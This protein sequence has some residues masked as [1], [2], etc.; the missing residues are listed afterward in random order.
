MSPT[1]VSDFFVATPRCVFVRVG[2]G[3]EAE[4]G[5]PYLERESKSAR[6]RRRRLYT[7]LHTHSQRSKEFVVGE[8][9]IRTEDGRRRRGP[10]VLAL[11]FPSR[12]CVVLAAPFS[13]GRRLRRVSLS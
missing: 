9:I 6:R 4:G 12:V 5:R 2:L 10:L 13:I 7:T 11:L 1:A 8:E 3:F